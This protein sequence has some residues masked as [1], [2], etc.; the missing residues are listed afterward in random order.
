MPVA[1]Q[2]LRDSA[3]SADDNSVTN[4]NGDVKH[5]RSTGISALTTFLASYPAV[6]FIRFQWVDL[7]GVLRTKVVTV[8]FAKSIVR[9]ERHVGG[10]VFAFQVNVLQELVEEGIE[11]KG[12]DELIPDWSTLRT[13]HSLDPK[14]ASVMCSVFEHRHGRPKPEYGICP[15]H[16]LKTVLEKAR[17]DCNMQFLVGFEIEFQIART[18]STQNPG[19]EYEQACFG[20]G[21]YAVSG[22]RDPIFSHV[23][24]AVEILLEAGIHV[25]TI[26][27][28]GCY[29]Q[30][31]MTLGPLRLMDA[32]DELVF[33]HD[34][35]KTVFSKH[36]LQV[37]MSPRPFTTASQNTGQH[38]H[39]STDNALLG[40]FFLQGLVQSL[41]S[42]CPFL[43]SFD[44]SYER[45][46]HIHI[47]N[48]TASC[49]E[50]EKNSTIRRLGRGYWDIRLS[51]A[52]ANMYLALAAVIS[53]GLEACQQNQPLTWPSADVQP[54]EAAVHLPTSLRQGLEL[55]EKDGCPLERVVG[56][57]IMT[58]YHLHSDE[59]DPRHVLLSGW[60]RP[61]QGT[62]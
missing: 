57:G 34:T 54:K 35:L 19:S 26:H 10:I 27:T 24:E 41:P 20:Q 9:G 44:I 49:S 36:G 22:L 4:G 5:V 29:G 45:S 40:E 59:E 33:V 47:G 39:I 15:R 25:E 56:G 6:S 46:T 58:A 42:L 11:W 55:L 62:Y 1:M 31:E 17:Q 8:V 16:I 53:A 43:L 23:E 37:A 21:H 51:D 3:L 13:R 61:R 60:V 18:T 2:V 52:T 32:I 48:G 7:C 28:E 14:H 12:H 38:M 30:Y 50:K